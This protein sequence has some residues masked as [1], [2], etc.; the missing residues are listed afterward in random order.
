MDLPRI[1]AHTVEVEAPP[2]VTWEALTDWMSS[3]S[4][5]QGTV[6]FARMLGC[7]Q[8]EVSGKPGQ[9]GSTIPGFRV[10]LADPPREL[11]LE[12]GHR[13]S[14]YTLNFQVEDRD[15]GRSLLSATT[16]AA[17]PG[18]KGQLYKTVVIRSRA[19]VLLTKGLLKSVAQRAERA[20]LDR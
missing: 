15:N 11:A 12:G 1:D 2:A 5:R 3:G 6:R 9:S 10:A 4:S 17:F 18:F 8:L 14:Q 7:D 20:T 16:H 13:F 19:H